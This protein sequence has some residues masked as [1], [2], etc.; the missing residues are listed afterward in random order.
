MLLVLQ[1][2]LGVVALIAA[3]VPFSGI[4]LGQRKEPG[5]EAANTSWGARAGSG[6]RSKIVPTPTR[7]PASMGGGVRS[8]RRT[9]A[10][11]RSRSRALE[12]PH[13]SHLPDE[14]RS[15]GDAGRRRASKREVP[16][17]MQEL[18]LVVLEL[19]FTF[20]F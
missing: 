3:A 20:L 5:M 17:L 15:S 4:R 16:V 11:V 9:A 12:L 8:S 19:I 13:A 1:L 2:I 14:I 7:K 10:T 18:P 6:S